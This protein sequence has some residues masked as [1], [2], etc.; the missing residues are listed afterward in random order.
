MSHVTNYR[1]LLDD[2][3]RVLPGWMNVSAALRWGAGR[4]KA[5]NDIELRSFAISAAWAASL[6]RLPHFARTSTFRW[7]L[8]IVAAF[9]MCVVVLLGFIDWRTAMYIMSENDVLLADQL[10]VFA[11]DTAQQRLEEI[12]DRLRKDPRRVKI[13]GIFGADGHRIAGNIEHL[14]PNLVPDVLTNASVARISSRGPEM[15]E[16]RLIAQPLPSGEIVVIGRNIDEIGKIA[17][18]IR[19]APVAR[20]RLCVRI[21]IEPMMFSRGHQRVTAFGL[22]LTAA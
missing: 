9:M 2:A 5:M 15:L 14:P 17:Q 13:V 11:S 18:I 21:P 22:H 20:P 8:V 19:R 1:I 6:A 4:A 7:T 3:H 16:V 10:Q 12:D